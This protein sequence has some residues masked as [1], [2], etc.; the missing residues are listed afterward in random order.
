MLGLE[1]SDAGK[2]EWHLPKT[3]IFSKRPKS[4]G[5]VGWVC[6]C[7]VTLVSL[8]F[9]FWLLFYTLSSFLRYFPLTHPL[10]LPH[11]PLKGQATGGANLKG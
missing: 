9:P 2:P 7:V 4:V 6:V 8:P 1:T 10:F 3:P 11:T 5:R